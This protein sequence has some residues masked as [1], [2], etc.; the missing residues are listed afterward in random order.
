[1]QLKLD[2]KF[3]ESMQLKNI[4]CIII[5]YTALEKATMMKAIPLFALKADAASKTAILENEISIVC[6][7]MGTV[8]CL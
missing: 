3:N 7:E 8:S 6:A 2:R 1:M 5:L 4:Y